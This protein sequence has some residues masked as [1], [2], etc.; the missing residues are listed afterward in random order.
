MCSSLRHLHSQTRELTPGKGGC[1][2]PLSS[3]VRSHIL[4]KARLTKDMSTLGNYI[5]YTAFQSLQRVTFRCYLSCYFDRNTVPPSSQVFSVLLLNFIPKQLTLSHKGL[6]PERRRGWRK[7]TLPTVETLV[8]FC[9][10]WT[11]VRKLYCPDNLNKGQIC[12]GNLRS[13]HLNTKSVTV[14]SSKVY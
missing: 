13:L 7:P 3:T 9:L 2:Q 14:L 12:V 1:M 11:D 6:G 4:E 10:D 5:L 8:D